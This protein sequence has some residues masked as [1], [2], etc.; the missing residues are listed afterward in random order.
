MHEMKN[1][2]EPGSFRDRN[3]RI[4]YSDN[5]V[6]RA[7]SKK[8]L[9]EWEFLSSRKFFSRFVSE[10]KIART[11]RV[12]DV[13]HLFPDENG[14]WEAFLRHEPIPLISY[15]YEWS[16]G[17]LK[18][19]A[20]LQIELL[21]AALDE[22]MILK[23]SS[24][25]NIQW[26]GAHP[27][28][29]DIPSFEKLSPG[30]PWIGYRQFCQMFLYPL[31]LQAYKNVP[32]QPWFRGNIDGLDPEYFHN[33]MSARDLLRP[34]VFV[35]AYLQA[36]AQMKYGDNPGDIKKNL[37]DAGFNREMIK[38]NVKGIQ[39]IIRRLSWTRS[40]SQW[41]HYANEHSYSDSDHEA[42]KSFVGTIISSQHW[43]VVWDIGCNTGIF[44][45]IAAQ[46]SEYVLAMDGDHLAVEFLYQELKKE[47]HS[48][49]LPLVFNVADPSPCLGW[50]GLERKALS[51]RGKPELTLCLALIHHIVI[52]ANIPLKEFIDWL[53]SLGS[54]LIIEF[55]TRED[56]M[57]KKL[58]RNKEDTYTDYDVSNFEHCLSGVFDVTRREEL[59]SGTRILYYAK[60]RI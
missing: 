33:M 40:T 2:I 3:G 6:L 13:N 39:K 12:D 58:L 26:K 60:A 36:K 53:G 32:F 16:F 46:N 35:H 55:V 42:K 41:S 19:A 23:D 50:R 49:I 43:K 4:F 28:Y 34:G 31:M 51:E 7:L 30:E 54:A 44:S 18:D 48:R 45:R 9:Q 38:N 47:E 59:F 56:P 21:L 52:T 22:D 14:K 15:P 25:F 24:A 27:V 57:V 11:E 8:A 10:G 17:M 5:A 1:H 20:L 29:I 37:S